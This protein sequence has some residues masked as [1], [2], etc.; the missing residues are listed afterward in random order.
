[1]GLDIFQLASEIISNYKKNRFRSLP[2]AV[3]FKRIESKIRGK[4]TNQSKEEIMDNLINNEG[5]NIVTDQKGRKHIIS[6]G[7]Y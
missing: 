3:Y 5:L 2:L 7:I 1:M 4:L 6:G